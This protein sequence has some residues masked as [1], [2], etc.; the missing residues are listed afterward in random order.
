MACAVLLMLAAFATQSAQAQTFKVLYSF[1]GKSDGSGPGGGVVLDTKGNLYGTTGGGG[2]DNLGAVFEV[3]TARKETVLYSFATPTDGAFPFATLARDAAGNLYGTTLY[4]GDLK[5]HSGLCGTVFKVTT[6][7][8]EI[9]LHGFKDGTDGAAPMAGVILDSKG[10]LYGTAAVGGDLKCGGIYAGCGVVFRLSPTGN[11]KVLYS[12][13]KS[14]GGDPEAS[15]VRD[16][17][18]NLYGTTFGG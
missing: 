13:K 18:G 3:N 7:R 14:D 9:V 15:L 12:F 8:K 6:N 11:P 10:N 16:G 5:C 1:K 2:A 4:G 17:S